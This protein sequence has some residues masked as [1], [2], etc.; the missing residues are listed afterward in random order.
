V[1]KRLS[2]VFSQLTHSQ[3]KQ[4]SL[5]S[6]LS[7]LT[8]EGFSAFTDGFLSKLER[9]NLGRYMNNAGVNNLTFESVKAL[10][11][12]NFSKLNELDLHMCGLTNK[13]VKWLL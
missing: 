3:V 7:K 2:S 10:S 8:G 9:F 13:T 1:F 4:L 6:C 12:L 5:S 11:R